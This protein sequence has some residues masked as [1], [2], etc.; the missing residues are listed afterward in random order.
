MRLKRT[1]GF[2]Y[3]KIVVVPERRTQRKMRAKNRRPHQESVHDQQTATGMPTQY[4]AR[5]CPKILVN[6]R[7]QFQFDE[8][9]ELR[10][11]LRRRI[12][13][14]SSGA[15]RI[16]QRDDDKIGHLV[17]INEH[18]DDVD[19]LLESSRMISV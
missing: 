15:R 5:L 13:P 1:S 16:R 10:R 7:N 14:I 9:Q 18:S 8:I 12:V 11:L 4:T 17:P 2:V 19:R 3:D 6:I